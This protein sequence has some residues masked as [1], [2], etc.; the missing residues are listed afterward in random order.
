[1]KVKVYNQQGKEVKELELPENIFGLDF[2]NDLVSQVLYIQR[3]K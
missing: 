1:M 3:C 2:N